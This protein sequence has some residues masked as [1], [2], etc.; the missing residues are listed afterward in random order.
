MAHEKDGKRR[1]GHLVDF[2][3]DWWWV[4]GRPKRKRREEETRS[5]FHPPPVEDKANQVS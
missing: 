2:I 4:K 1:S 3:F 5:S